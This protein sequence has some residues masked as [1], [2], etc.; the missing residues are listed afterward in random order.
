MG[1][2]VEKIGEN[3]YRIVEENQSHQDLLNSQVTM[4][5]YESNIFKDDFEETDNK[6]SPYLERKKKQNNYSARS[7]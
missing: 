5:N 3:W 7:V 1:R 4:K 2:R 6:L